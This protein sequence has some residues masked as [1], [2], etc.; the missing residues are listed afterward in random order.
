MTL[1][2][3][4]VEMMTN[5]IVHFKTSPWLSIDGKTLTILYFKPLP[6]NLQLQNTVR[7]KVL[8]LKKHK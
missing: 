5:G 4:K 8:K 7:K 2:H 6:Q 1:L 3:V